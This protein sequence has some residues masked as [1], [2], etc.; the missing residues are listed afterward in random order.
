[1]KRS[2]R[3]NKAVVP[4]KKEAKFPTDPREI[5]VIRESYASK[6][7]ELMQRNQE[8]KESRVNLK[9]ESSSVLT[10]AISNE[11]EARKMTTLARKA[12]RDNA[13]QDI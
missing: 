8:L 13:F 5:E 9:N 2:I 7:M 3:K 12:K 6:I 10:Q 4:E 1:M 11:K